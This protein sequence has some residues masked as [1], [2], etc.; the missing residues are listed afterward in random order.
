[1]IKKIENCLKADLFCAPYA[2]PNHSRHAQVERALTTNRY[3]HVIEI[4]YFPDQ[5]LRQMKLTYRGSKKQGRGR[6]RDFG[7]A[8]GIAVK[9]IQINKAN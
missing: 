5:R 3:D 7:T 2:G 8:E 9:L 1:M 6:S 4:C